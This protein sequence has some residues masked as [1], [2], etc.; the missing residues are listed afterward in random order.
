MILNPLVTIINFLKNHVFENFAFFASRVN[1]PPQNACYIK[2]CSFFGIFGIS[3]CC[4]AKS[5][6]ELAL[7]HL[8]THLVTSKLCLG[9]KK[10]G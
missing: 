8:R 4:N 5:W 10:N 9:E 1:P 7:K 2:K 3:K 6:C